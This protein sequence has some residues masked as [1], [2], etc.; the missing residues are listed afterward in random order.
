MNLEVINR[1]KS[2]MIVILVKETT[3]KNTMLDGEVDYNS[4]CFGV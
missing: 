1:E 4:I 3:K 2:Y